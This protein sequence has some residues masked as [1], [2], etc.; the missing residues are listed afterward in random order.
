MRRWL[1][2]DQG[3]RY[4]QMSPSEQ[5]AWYEETQRIWDKQRIESE[6]THPDPE[7]EE[8]AI[9]EAFKKMLIASFY[10]V[11][12]EHFKPITNYLLRTAGEPHRGEITLAS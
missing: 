11:P 1:R 7:S 9:T 10:T 12:D 2:S 4:R 8:L 5:K 3:E 6:K